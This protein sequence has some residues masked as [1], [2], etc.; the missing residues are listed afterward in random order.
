[1]NNGIRPIRYLPQVIQV[2]PKKR[3]TGRKDGKKDEQ[4]FSE[5]ITVSD[6]DDKNKKNKRGN[7][8]QK[9][10]DKVVEG[11]EDLSKTSNLD[12]DCGTIIDVEA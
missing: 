7:L 1:M 3:N 2:S 12:E 11:K 9:G 8:N 4:E 10:A 6:G 5:H